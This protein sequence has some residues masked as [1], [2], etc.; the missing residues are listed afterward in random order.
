MEQKRQLGLPLVFLRTAHQGSFSNPKGPENLQRTS[1]WTARQ[2]SF[3]NPRGP[4]D[5]QRTSLPTSRQQLHRTD[6]G[7]NCVKDI[8]SNQ[9]KSLFIFFVVVVSY[10]CTLKCVPFD[11]IY[12]LNLSFSV[13]SSPLFAY[14]LVIC[15][16]KG[17][18][19]IFQQ[20]W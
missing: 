19:R 3:S 4:E 12:A 11:I 5:L 20:P 16:A 13:L 18:F 10:E 17:S 6:L 1:L 7:M 9:R 2:G 14:F 15:R 8:N